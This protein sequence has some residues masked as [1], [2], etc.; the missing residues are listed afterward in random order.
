[1]SQTPFSS[2][3]SP[4]FLSTRIVTPFPHFLS[5]SQNPT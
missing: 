5:F 1:L 2:E 4:D 3:I